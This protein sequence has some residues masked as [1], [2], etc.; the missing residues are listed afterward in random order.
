IIRAGRAN[1]FLSDV[2]AQTFVDVTGAPVELCQTD[3]SV[4]AA[5][6]AGLGAGIYSDATAAFAN[7]KP[8]K[9]VIPEYDKLYNSLYGEWK[10]LL[11]KQFRIHTSLYH[12]E[13]VNR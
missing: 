9:L 1:M 3:G 12:T 2:F 6:G 5:L 4:G 11:E 10:I 7:R 13:Q 8:L